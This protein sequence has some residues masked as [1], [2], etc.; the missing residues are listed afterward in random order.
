[1]AEGRSGNHLEPLK[2][3]WIDGQPILQATICRCQDR[4]VPTAISHLQGFFYFLCYAYYLFETPSLCT[5][6]RLHMTLIYSSL[7]I[8]F[9]WAVGWHWPKYLHDH[10]H[11]LIIN[12]FFCVLY[13]W[14][15]PCDFCFY[16][17]IVTLL[18]SFILWNLSP[19]HPRLIGT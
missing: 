7:S 16:W 2:R 19:T 15:S 3:G 9:L 8:I 12:S 6:F 14:L 5:V 13:R 11:F 4:V 1:M 10:N 17:M 18:F